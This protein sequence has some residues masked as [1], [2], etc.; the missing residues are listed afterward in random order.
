MKKKMKPN[1][2]SCDGMKNSQ[3][4]ARGVTIQIIKKKKPK[5]VKEKTELTLYTLQDKLAEKSTK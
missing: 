2:Y 5:K 4:N 3:R 1:N